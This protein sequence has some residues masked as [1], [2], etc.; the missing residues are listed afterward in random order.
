[1]LIDYVSW[2]EKKG[3]EYSAFSLHTIKLQDIL[4]IA[5]ESKIA[6]EKCDI[7]LM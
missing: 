4:S 6:F 7:L 5:W 3:I 2:A 1:M